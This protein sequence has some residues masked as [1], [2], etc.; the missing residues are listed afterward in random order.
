VAAERLFLDTNVLVYATVA[1]SPW[2]TVASQAIETRQDAGVELW[3]SRQIIREY[4]A[5]L[6][7]PRTFPNPIPLSTLLVEVRLFNTRF[8]IAD[9]NQAVTTYLLDVIEQIPSG[10]AQVHDAN[11]VATMRVSGV[12]NLLTHNTADFARFSHLI[13]VV[14]L[15]GADTP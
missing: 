11:I 8:R 3:I 14:P 9:E 6:T 15:V 10:G 2:H 13:T 12:S 5:T 1:E 4:L 7:R